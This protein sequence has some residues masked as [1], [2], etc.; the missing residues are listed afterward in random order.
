MESLKRE[1]LKAVN[2]K[3]EAL[4]VNATRPDSCADYGAYQFEVGRINALEETKNLFRE[5]WRKN[6]IDTDDDDS[7]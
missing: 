4:R 6:Q 3:I 5:V 1:F 2:E 7:E